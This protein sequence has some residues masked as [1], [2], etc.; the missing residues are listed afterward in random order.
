MLSGPL[1]F[2]GDMKMKSKALFFSVAGIVV[3]VGLL[4]GAKALQIGSMIKH[5]QAAKI[6][7]EVVTAIQAQPQTWESLVTAVGSLEAVQGVTVTA[8]LTGKITA[9]AFEPGTRIKAGEL[10]VQQDIAAETAQLR[11]AEA[12]VVLAGITLERS[13]KM[14]ATKVVAEANYDNADAQLK[15]ALAQAD[16][17]RA[18]I[19]KKTIR[20]PFSGRLGLR[21]VNLGQIIKEGAAIVSLQA[22]DP[23]FVNFLVPQQQLPQM[24]VGH[25]VRITSD[26]LPE[27]QVVDGVITAINPDVDAASRNVRVQATVANPNELL[28]PGMFANVAVV[29]PEKNQVLT[30]PA[31]AV[32]Y[33]PYSDSVFIVEEAKAEEG[34]VGGQVVRQQFVRLGEQRG[35]FVAVVSGLAPEQTVVSTGVFKLRNGQAVV[36]DNALAPEFQLAPQPKDG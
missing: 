36:V 8:E 27:G 20:A 25:A 28:R 19:A 9:I 34:G 7:P 31:T 5:G 22:L 23:I 24:H 29:L 12:A 15:Q 30:I 32:L 21:L 26:G 11:S 6:P 35:D 14:L 3:V 2:C 18:T 4:A 1:F 13:R 17:I 16:N 33:A 10:L